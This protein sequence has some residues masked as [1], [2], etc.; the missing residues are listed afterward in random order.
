MIEQPY[1]RRKREAL[2]DEARLYRQA[3]ASARALSR[4]LTERYRGLE[5]RLQRRWRSYLESAPVLPY[6]R[7]ALAEEL[8]RYWQL[9]DAPTRTAIAMQLGDDLA[10]VL[11][12]S[13]KRFGGKAPDLGDAALA[14]LLSG[15]ES[16]AQR[17]EGR[18]TQTAATA[19]EQQ[20]SFGRASG[21]MRALMARTNTEAATAVITTSYEAYTD[22]RLVMLRERG[23]ELVQVLTA[24]DD[25][26]CPYCAEREG[27]VYALE[28][29]ELP[30][31]LRCRCIAIPVTE[32]ELDDDTPLVI[33]ST[34]VR[35]A[36]LA[37][38]TEAG[39]SPN[40]GLTPGERYRGLTEP[41]R[42]VWTP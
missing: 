31:H 20:L 42:P 36:T 15:L 10:A 27:Y 40:P 33:E 32:A 41:T 22:A 21:L 37:A 7:R 23:V 3:Q 38:L 17:G 8:S 11:T 28:E 12:L 16:I 6:E 5:G 25:R 39:R 18:L 30:W 1:L 19:V 2:V 24:G 4:R 34:Q 26:V 13:A 35:E 14:R 9:L 29:L